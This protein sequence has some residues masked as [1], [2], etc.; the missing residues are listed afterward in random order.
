MHDHPDGVQILLT[1]A[2]AR[3]TTADGKV[4]EISGKARSA[5]YR[6]ALSHTVENT[7][8]QFEGILVDLK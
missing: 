3:Q 7:G 5:R 8:P 1:D 6:A 4:A 2:R